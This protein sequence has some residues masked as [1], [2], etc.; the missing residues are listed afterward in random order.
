MFFRV[1]TE[2]DRIPVYI[3]LTDESSEG[4]LPYKLASLIPQLL[5]A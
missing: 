3:K 5:K 4:S 1:S 2:N